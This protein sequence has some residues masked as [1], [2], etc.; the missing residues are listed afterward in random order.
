MTAFPMSTEI[1]M[2]G[3]A[4]ALVLL[5]LV[6]QASSGAMGLGLGYLMGPRD[7][8]KT[9][10]NVYAGRMSRALHNVLET[11]PLFA[12]L[13]LAVVVTGRSGGTAALGAQVYVWARA[14]YVPVYVLG[15]PVLRTI[16]WAASMVGIVMMLW[17]L[18]GK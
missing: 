3:C 13:A 9:V 12:A 10:S 16:V 14:I 2:L 15:I 7:E 11:F 4:I 8:A 18:L 5:Q 1:I 6:L 17:V